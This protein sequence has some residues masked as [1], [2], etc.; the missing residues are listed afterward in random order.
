VDD[1]DPGPGADEAGDEPT[2]R[3]AVSW[4][5]LFTFWA[6]VI[7]A[8]GAPVLVLLV[9]GAPGPGPGSA[10]AVGLCPAG[11]ILDLI[12]AETA[13]LRALLDGALGPE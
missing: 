3:P 4:S 7:L 6:G 5:G 11:P 2:R 13:R 12:E 9:L 10:E 1:D 8:F